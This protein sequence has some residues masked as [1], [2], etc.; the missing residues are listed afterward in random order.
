MKKLSFSILFG[1][2]LLMGLSLNAQQLSFPFEPLAENPFGLPNPKANPAIK[3]FAP[4]IGL[5]N[6]VSQAR[7]ADQTWAEP[8]AMTWRFKYIM[9]GMAVQDETLKANGVHSGSIRQFNSDSLKWYVHYYTSSA[10][11]AT[12]PAWEGNVTA[13][14][15]KVVLYKEQKAPNEPKVFS[16]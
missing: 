9:N 5:C 2:V 6:C 16:D 14:K 10:A 8:E 12:L 11:V 15:D 13:E 3:D 7:N 4:M 1:A